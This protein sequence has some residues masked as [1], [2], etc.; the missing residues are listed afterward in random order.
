MPMEL[1]SV[2]ARLQPP[3][4]DASVAVAHP[5]HDRAALREGRAWSPGTT[6]DGTIHSVANGGGSPTQVGCSGGHFG[7]QLI[8]TDGTLVYWGD[9]ESLYRAP[10]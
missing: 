7:Q 3:R 1:P 8:A 9:T 4:T 6:A 5:A 10:K 2:S